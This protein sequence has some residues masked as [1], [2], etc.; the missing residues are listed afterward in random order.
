MTKGVQKRIY[1]WMITIILAGASA[2]SDAAGPDTDPSG[3]YNLRSIDNQNLPHTLDDRT[4]YKLEVLIGSLRIREDSSFIESI[5]TREIDGATT[6]VQTR[7]TRGTWS[8]TDD[9]LTMTVAGIQTTAALQDRD[10]IVEVDSLVYVYR[11]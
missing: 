8:R 4:G 7:E 11:R 6:T 1:F 3:T 9:V 5:T 10:I 2:C